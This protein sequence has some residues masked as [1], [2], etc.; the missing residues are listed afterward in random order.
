VIVDYAA[1]TDEALAIQLRGGDHV[2]FAQLM[3]RHNARCLRY[4]CKLL[5]NFA[6]AEEEVQN[7][8]MHVYQ[9]IG[10]FQHRAKFSRWLMQILGNQCRMHFRKAIKMPFVPIHDE[11][12]EAQPGLQIVEEGPSP[13]QRMIRLETI[14]FANQR[15][16]ALPSV[17]REILVL[18]YE[19]HWPI[20]QI[21]NHLGLSIAGTKSRILRGRTKLRHHVL[22]ATRRRHVQRVA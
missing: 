8:F 18:R 12:D 9:H 14:T 5:G 19:H 22:S 6:E 13:E 4:A 2:A 3:E 21:A 15:I 7:T 17:Y 16:D 20:S 1:L 11:F 10:Q